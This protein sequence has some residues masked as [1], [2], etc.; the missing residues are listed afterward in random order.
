LL[1]QGRLCPK[2]LAEK[3]LESKEPKV[4]TKE[5]AKRITEEKGF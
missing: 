2:C 3:E 1:Q 4:L 5:A